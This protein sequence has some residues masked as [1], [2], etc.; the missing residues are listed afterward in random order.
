MSNRQDLCA[1]A[2]RFTESLL[3]LY[4]RLSSGGPTREH[5]AKQAFKAVS[6]IGAN[7]EEGRVAK[8]RRDMAQKYVISLRESREARYW[9]RLLARDSP[10]AADLQ[11]LIREASEFVAMLTVSVRHLREKQDERVG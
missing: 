4:P 1:R 6:A 2:F 8:G 11:P 10:L 7:L 3:D 9:L 5:M